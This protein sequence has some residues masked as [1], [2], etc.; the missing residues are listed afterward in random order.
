[1]SA[2]RHPPPSEIRRLIEVFD[3]TEYPVIL[4]CARGSDRT[5]LASA[6]AVLLLTDGGLPAARRQMW[7]RYGHLNA[8]R[9]ALLDLFFDY[10][11]AALASRGETH[12]PDRFRK[13]V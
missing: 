4:H 8:G 11:E 9:T 12:T 7:P 5:G 6:V 10:Y 1:L 3:R 2:K 13:W